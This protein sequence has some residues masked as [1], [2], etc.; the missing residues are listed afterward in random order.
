[1]LT[2]PFLHRTPLR[3][4]IQPTSL[5]NPKPRRIISSLRGQ[6]RGSLSPHAGLAIEHNRLCLCL[7]RP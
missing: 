1:M 5:I 2:L 7:I 3:R 6:L 4:P